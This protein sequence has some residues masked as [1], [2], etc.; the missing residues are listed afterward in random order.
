MS[1]NLHISE[2]ALERFRER[3][4]SEA[5]GKAMRAAFNMA[6][7]VRNDLVAVATGLKKRESPD[8]EY[9][10][11]NNGIFVVKPP[12][13]PESGRKVVVT[14]LALSGTQWA[15]LDGRRSTPTEC[16]TE[17]HILT[18]PELSSR[19]HSRWRQRM[20]RELVSPCLTGDCPLNNEKV[21]G[22]EYA[23]LMRLFKEGDVPFK[24]VNNH[25]VIIN[26]EGDCP[27][28]LTWR[29]GEM[30]LTHKNNLPKHATPQ[31]A[32]EER[33]RE[34]MGS[35]AKVMWDSTPPSM[36]EDFY[37]V[38]IGSTPMSF[39]GPSGP[40]LH[41]EHAGIRIYWF[42]HRIHVCSLRRAA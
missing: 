8:S 14:F 9:F 5:D 16:T 21:R 32:A 7:L 20:F 37:S 41:W 15:M 38:V 31:F 35:T 18:A 1:V 40:E 24:R 23:R 6:V 29:N 3:Y 33:I 22:C 30:E 4:D 39:S 10:H 19:G 28:Q 25:E 11:Y 12:G 26:P 13:I 36:R 17:T 2:H 27:L 42:R 34:L